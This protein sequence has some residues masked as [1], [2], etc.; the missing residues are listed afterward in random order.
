V[1]PSITAAGSTLAFA[2]ASSETSAETFGPRS[3]A[4][5]AAVISTLLSSPTANEGTSFQPHD[6]AHGATAVQ[7]TNSPSS[8]SAWHE[9]AWDAALT[10]YAAGGDS[11]APSL[12]S[13][14]ATLLTTRHKKLPR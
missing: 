12:E 8:S 6:T 1:K 9:A 5:L 7:P 14:L 3:T 10:E 2:T 4:A 13:E 11:L